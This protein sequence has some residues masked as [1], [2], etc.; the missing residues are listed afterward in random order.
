M[1]TFLGGVYGD[2]QM[3]LELGEAGLIANPDDEQIVNNLAFIE[4]SQG[5]LVAA[6][7]RIRGI[8]N[9]KSPHFVANTG[10]L[11][12]RMGDIELG[13]KCYQAAIRLSKLAGQ[14]QTESLATLFL[15]VRHCSPET[16]SLQRLLRL[17]LES[18]QSMKQLA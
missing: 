14:P 13:R 16:H 8:A 15:R 1:G 3:G 4:A 6:W 10:L 5:N 12:Y 11:A 2:Y 7:Q 17:P 18:Q 9:D